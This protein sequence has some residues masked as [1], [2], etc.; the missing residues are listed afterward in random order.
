MDTCSPDICSK[1]SLTSFSHGANIAVVGAGGGIGKAL[2]DCLALDDNRPN[3]IALNRGDVRRSGWK[4]L[5]K[6]L[7]LENESSIKEASEFIR[8][9]M[10]NLSAVIVATGLLHDDTGIKPEKSWNSLDPY[11]IERVYRVNTV[12]PALVA[13]YFLPLLDDN[14]KSVFACLSARVGS[15]SDNVLG[16]WYAYRA[17]KAA[18]NMILKNLSIELRRKNKNAICVGLHPGTVSTKLSKPFSNNVLPETI[19]S[20][21]QAAINL[22]SLLNDFTVSD[23][24]KIFAYDGSIIP[25]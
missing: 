19:V 12:G 14:C 5:F 23:S 6:S 3:I 24:G 2:I 22:L 18:L 10:G 25:Y 11:S 4:G 8:C 9:K 20:P 21:E 1:S 13:K 15:I 7:E 17:S 16:G